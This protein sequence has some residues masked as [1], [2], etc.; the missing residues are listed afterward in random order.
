MKLVVCGGGISGITSA[1]YASRSL[2]KTH[3]SKFKVL[4]LEKESS[5]GGW[6]KTNAD[7]GEKDSLKLNVSK[8]SLYPQF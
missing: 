5:V 4:V 2:T 7:R 6:M 1:L 3:G 8:I